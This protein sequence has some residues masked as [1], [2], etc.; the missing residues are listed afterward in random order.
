MSQLG[1]LALRGL[2]GGVFVVLFS[3]LGELLRPKSFAGI[4]TAAPS[5]ALASLLITGLSRS[6]AV[7][8]SSA[9]GMTAGAVA[10][11]AACLVGIVAVRRF[12]ALRGA[13]GAV[14]VWLLVAV[15]LY[16]AVLR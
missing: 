3:L 9:L 15:G 5:V 8:W 13:L 2:V 16:A 14:M 12:R 6:E 1:L 4:L 7:V 11:I 10:L